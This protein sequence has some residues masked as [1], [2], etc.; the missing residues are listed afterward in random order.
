LIGG[1]GLPQKLG[2]EKESRSLGLLCCQQFWEQHPLHFPQLNFCI[3]LLGEQG[4]A[5]SL[6]SPPVFWILAMVLEEKFSEPKKGLTCWLSELKK[7]LLGVKPD[8]AV[9]KFLSFPRYA[10]AAEILRHFPVWH[11]GQSSGAEIISMAKVGELRPLAAAIPGNDIGRLGILDGWFEI[12]QEGLVTDSLLVELFDLTA[13]EA[14]AYRLAVYENFLLSRP[15]ARPRYRSLVDV[16]RHRL[17][18]LQKLF[19]REQLR[20]MYF[21]CPAYQRLAKLLNNAALAAAS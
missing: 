5:L 17:R 18:L 10:L 14:E 15:H 6:R 11:L 7:A 8:V 19:T 13:H 4:A 1:I 3:Q 20:M 9:L 16:N 21:G 12:Q 2:V